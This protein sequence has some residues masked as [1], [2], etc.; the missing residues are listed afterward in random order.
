MAAAKDATENLRELE[1]EPGPAL[2]FYLC[3][4]N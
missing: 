4:G 2:G 3:L 1:D